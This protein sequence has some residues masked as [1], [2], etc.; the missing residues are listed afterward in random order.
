MT[1]VLSTSPTVPDP[2]VVAEAAAVLRAGDVVAIPTETV[3]G[4]A[5]NAT[6]TAAVEK[7][8]AAKGRPSW[9]PLI[10]HI[11]DAGALDVVARNVPA[12]AR[13]LAAHFW[14]GP[15]TIVL[16]RS[17]AVPDAVTGGR[18]TVGIRMPSH[19]VARAIIRAAGVP[20][21]APSANRFMEVSPTTAAHVL[22]GLGGRIPLVIDAG[23]TAVGIE[24]TVID[25]T[26]S[27][28]MLL[29]PGAVTRDQL[30]PLTG[31]LAAPATAL[32]PDAVRPAPGMM[33]R[34][35]APR[36]RLVLFAAR[37]LDA[38]RARADASTTAGER[39]AILT[40]SQEVI[41]PH[42]IRMPLDS[43]GYA[44]R[45][46]EALHD[47]DAGGVTTAWIEALPDDD[48]WEGVRDRVHRATET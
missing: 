19:P 46:Y 28:P 21:A 15:L 40:R 45:L 35:Y 13:T 1:R 8:F 38:V 34:H 11:A 36:A 33:D 5:A 4:L 31:R 42:I 18:D 26:V 27:P 16:P 25:L 32:A 24:S 44:A 2:A 48:A 10:V 43:A 39:V 7:I 9:N 12:L 6:D 30:E 23:P 37:D 22:S 41:G 14:P 17:P 29:R 3:Y 47:L 20:V